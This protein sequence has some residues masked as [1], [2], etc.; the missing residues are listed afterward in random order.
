[1]PAIELYARA[2]GKPAFIRGSP[3]RDHS[4]NNAESFVSCKQAPLLAEIL[5]S[6]TSDRLVYCFTSLRS[7]CLF[8]IQTVSASPRSTCTQAGAGLCKSWVVWWGGN[9]CSSGTSGEARTCRSRRGQFPTAQ[10]K[11]APRRLRSCRCAPRRWSTLPRGFLWRWQHLRRFADSSWCG[12]GRRERR[13]V[14]KSCR[15]STTLRPT[16]T[17]RSRKN[18]RSRCLSPV[19]PR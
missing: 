11:R 19:L 14:R 13:A 12:L 10:Y 3:C 5:D 18:V 1:M 17:R 15:P 4:H 6:G 7:P 2:K 9:T 16:P 8:R